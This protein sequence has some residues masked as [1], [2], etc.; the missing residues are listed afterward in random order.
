M[1]AAAAH[2][3]KRKGQLLGCF[4]ARFLL[5]CRSR[6]SPVAAMS[7]AELEPYMAEQEWG[8]FKGCLGAGL[9][10]SLEGNWAS[11]SGVLQ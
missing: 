9:Y 6:F 8:I 5:S 4:A 7:L 10:G 2:R 3:P 11:A 1:E